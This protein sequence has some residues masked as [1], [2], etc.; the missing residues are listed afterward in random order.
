MI[1]LA[2]MICGFLRFFLCIFCAWQLIACAAKPS[3]NAQAAKLRVALAQEY[4]QVKNL[5]G[6]KRQLDMALAADERYASAYTM[7]AI[8]LQ[9]EGSQY[10]FNLAEE[11]FL[12]AIAL[13]ATD[14]FGYFYYALYLVEK[15]DTQQAAKYFEQVG[16]QLGYAGRLAALEN[17]AY[18]YYQDWKK[19]P[20]QSNQLLA[21]T[22]LNRAMQAGST[23]ENLLIAI[24]DLHNTK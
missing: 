21:D 8:L 20:T 24:S 17:L 12:K 23:D 3:G 1:K 7:M 5:D 19:D 16:S 11:Y 9:S 13:D 10:N 2:R 15:G 6:A 18:I 14:M 22:A 4:Y